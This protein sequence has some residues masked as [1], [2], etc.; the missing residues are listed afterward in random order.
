MFTTKISPFDLESRVDAEYYS[1]EAINCLK[2][3]KSFDEHDS[4]G[5]IITQGYRVVYHGTDSTN[6]LEKEHMLPFLSPSQIDSDGHIDFD[7]VDTLPL[8]YK[9]KYP[10]GLAHPDELLIEVKGNVSKLAIVPKSIPQN[11]MVSGSLYKA[12]ISVDYDSR[13]VLSFLKSQHGQ[14]LKS[15]L[16]SNT[17][18]SYIAK[19]DLYSIPVFRINKFAQSYIGNKVRQAEL[20]R[21]WARVI[22]RKVN[23][24][25]TSYIPD[26]TKLNFKKKTRVV[27]T[28]QM[29]ERM[30][31]H[32]YPG[33]VDTYLQDNSIGF[34]KLS[35]CC[36]GLFNGQTQ[37]TTNNE[38]CK[39]ITVTN[40]S[41]HFVKGKARLVV[42]PKT[43]DKFL[44]KY[45]L[46][47][48]NAAHQK[49]YIG[50]DIT[51]NHSDQKILPSTEVMVI[52]ANRDKVPASYLRAYFQTKL[53]FIQIQ[54]TIRGITA[55]SYPV[56][57]AKLD[58]FVPELND[59]EKV[60]WFKADE[61]LEIA[62]EASELATKLI[63]SSKLIVE[64][65]IEGQITEIQLMEAQQA[66]E[67]SDNSKDIVI[68]S[69][70]TDKGYLA[71]GGKPLFTDLDKLYELL[72]EAN[73]A[74]EEDGEFV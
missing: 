42:K 69:K 12:R 32:F 37:A 66:L 57:M 73:N 30:D 43:S 10:K 55:H 21:E 22:D 70:L 49:S 25:H 60:E 8:Y 52:R 3:V 71:E 36:L 20:L 39:Q 23:L 40:L 59:D 51:F 1:P 29:T 19:D 74:T 58:I 35:D 7:K 67:E 17:I 14:I 26:Q 41:P 9:D 33:V 68:L 15:R 53:G 46:L 56:D 2:Q 44:N 6:G 24:F 38:S 13:F 61:L 34:E 72:D 45:D 65:L 27:S 63:Q 11:L 5:G 50:R 28:R 47:I 31:A 16:T 62:G 64:S 48:C 18:I 4:I 54:S